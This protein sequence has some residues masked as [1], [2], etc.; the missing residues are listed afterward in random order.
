MLKLIK[1]TIISLKQKGLI[2][3]I[4]RIIEYPFFILKD[5]DFKKTVL[6]LKNAEDRFTA[7]YKKDIWGN[8]ESASGFGS[9]LECTANLRNKL[10]ELFGKFSIKTIFDA[11]C[12]DFNWMGYVLKENSLNYIGGDIVAPLI[13]SNNLNYKN[14]AT[15]FIHID[16]TKENFPESDLMICRD[17]LFHLSF[18]DIKLVL[19]NFINSNIPYLLTTTHINADNFQN[20]DIATGAFRK[21][22]LFVAPFYFPKDVHFRIEDDPEENYWGLKREMCLWTRQQVID[23][24]KRFNHN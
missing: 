14:S 2:K 20:K 17:C 23:V 21:I 19:E 8:E 12:G 22:D 9:T 10:P 11:P 6:A 15:K 4:T 13:E 1:K 16:L 18:Y 5:R 3:T 24:L 7:I